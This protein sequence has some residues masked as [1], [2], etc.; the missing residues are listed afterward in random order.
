MKI[1]HNLLILCLLVSG[2]ICFPSAAE[3]EELRKTTTTTTSTS[4]TIGS[5]YYLTTTST[6]QPQQ[7]I[8]TI[9]IYKYQYIN[10]T[11][12][13]TSIQE[14][15]LMNMIPTKCFSPPC[16]QGFFECKANTLNILNLK[17]SEFS[18][19]KQTNI[20]ELL[21]DIQTD[22][23][24][25]PIKNDGFGEYLELNANTWSLIKNDTKYVLKRI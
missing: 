17:K 19:R 18:E 16:S 21:R 8:Q 24:C 15:Y 3:R 13:L 7:H 22:K 6:V 5:F 14:N 4:T 23:T 1:N 11:L 2:C 9:N 25:F 12:D 10:E 20:M